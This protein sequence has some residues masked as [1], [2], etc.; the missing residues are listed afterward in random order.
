MIV[1]PDWDLSES[2]EAMSASNGA[3]EH[4]QLGISVLN[5]SD[6]D[7]NIVASE[8]VLHIC[9]SSNFRNRNELSNPSF[10]SIGPSE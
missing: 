6:S 3:R 5:R 8:V 4:L 9:L 7:N 1:V 2:F 10:H